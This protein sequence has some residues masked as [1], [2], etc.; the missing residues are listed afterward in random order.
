MAG[1]PRR[2]STGTPRD[3]AN[4]KGVTPGGSRVGSRLS[5]ANPTPQTPQTPL[6][7]SNDDLDPWSSTLR[8]SARRA[9]GRVE[10]VNKNSDRQNQLAQPPA[11]TRRRS[12]PNLAAAA[13][14][15]QFAVV[16]QTERHN[17]AGARATAARTATATGQSAPV[18]DDPPSR[19]GDK[20]R[21][22]DTGNGAL[23]AQ[24]NPGLTNAPRQ[25]IGEVTLPAHLVLYDSSDDD[26][27]LEEIGWFKKRLRTGPQTEDT[28]RYVW[29]EQVLA[30]KFVTRRP[31]ATKFTQPEQLIGLT[32]PCFQGVNREAHINARRLND[33]LITKTILDHVVENG[34]GGLER[35]CQLYGPPHMG[36]FRCIYDLTIDPL[37]HMPELSLPLTMQKVELV[38]RR[39]RDFKMELFVFAR[40]DQVEPGQERPLYGWVRLD[41]P[42]NLP[43]FEGLKILALEGHR[44]FGW[45]HPG[46]SYDVVEREKP[47]TR[48]PLPPAQPSGANRG[49]HTTGSANRGRGRG[50]RG[51]G[52]AGHRER[53]HRQQSAPPVGNPPRPVMGRIT[54]VHFVVHW[55]APCPSLNFKKYPEADNDHEEND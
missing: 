36:L 15:P 8:R 6:L 32:V 42:E 27:A 45:V 49:R 1:T 53:V 7:N 50:G 14:D 13:T 34:Q 55:G 28:D 46:F 17:P 26:K 18:T 39:G 33:P 12:E 29:T 41:R 54:K 20:R 51:R 48:Q 35:A 47:E 40:D 4:Q 30:N 38:F 3:T 31:D 2:S 25:P 19:A 10:G 9:S 23:P 16:V 43:A 21:R 52:R 22:R 5:Q 11:A 24:Q 37:E 44:F